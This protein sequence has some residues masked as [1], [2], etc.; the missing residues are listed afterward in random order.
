MA[1]Y[2]NTP[3]IITSRTK[4]LLGR[5]PRTRVSL[6]HPCLSDRL[7]QKAE[8]S[9]GSRQPSKFDVNQ[10]VVVCDFQPHC[11][12]KWYKAT[13][14]KCLGPLTYEVV[15][16]GKICKV[17]VDHLCSWTDEPTQSTTII[18]DNKFTVNTMSEPFDTQEDNGNTSDILTGNEAPQPQCLQ[19]DRKPPKRL[20][21]ELD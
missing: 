7:T 11:P 15:M 4:V 13:I 5:S 14:S 3:H 19:R 10:K 16:E 12:D 17:H 6:V 8:A 9:V 21:E 1:S 2:R 20:I 18:D